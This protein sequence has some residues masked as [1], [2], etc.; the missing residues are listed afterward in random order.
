[1][2]KCKWGLHKVVCSA[3]FQ[4]IVVSHINPLRGTL[5][6]TGT[7]DQDWPNSYLRIN[8]KVC[9]FVTHIPWDA[10]TQFTLLLNTLLQH[11][12][13]L[14]K[15]LVVHS[16]VNEPVLSMYDFIDFHPWKEITCVTLYS[17]S[18]HFYEKLFSLCDH[19]RAL[20]PA[21]QVFLEVG[22]YAGRKYR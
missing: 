22:V 13:T 3:L 11:K 5:D 18:L 20:F 4:E 16:I 8:T 15:S 12:V 21:E 1:M 9:E 19:G 2:L 10:N 6:E 17:N 7:E 14:I